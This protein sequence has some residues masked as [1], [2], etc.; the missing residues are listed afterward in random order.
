MTQTPFDAWKTLREVTGARIALGRAGASL[1]TRELLDFELA[2]ARARDSVSAPFDDYRLAAELAPVGLPIMRLASQASDR[3]EYLL[4][5]DRGRQLCEA[6]LEVLRN[7]SKPAEE[8]D[9]VVVVTDGLS[10]PAAHAQVPV[11]L[12][13]LLPRF[14]NDGWRIAPLCLARFGRVAIADEI[15]QSLGA[16]MALVLLGE[17]PGLGAADSLGAYFV[18]DPRPGRTDAERN[19]VSN[20]RPEGLPIPL[21]V[22]TLHYLMSRARTKRLT[23]VALKDDRG[24]S[25]LNVTLAGKLAAR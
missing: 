1:P 17:R 3:L 16:R 18:Y 7:V 21:A 5:P 24:L 15:G 10:P 20:I 13:E 4:R 19:C 11:L 14:G 6:S 2:H 12:R 9:L 8:F 25:E 22:E 23:G